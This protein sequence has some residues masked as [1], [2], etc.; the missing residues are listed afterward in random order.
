MSR[1]IRIVAPRESTEDSD[2][3][4]D[5]AA[6]GEQPPSYVPGEIL[7]ADRTKAAEILWEARRRGKVFVRRKS[8]LVA[9]GA[10][11][12]GVSSAIGATA[13]LAHEKR[14]KKSPIAR[15]G[16]QLPKPKLGKP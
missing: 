7:I 9:I 8:A 5:Q 2:V 13:W 1:P 3:L 15:I 12:I 6:W 10:A 4:A 16:D 14:K 11:V